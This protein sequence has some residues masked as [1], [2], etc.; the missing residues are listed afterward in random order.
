M[1]ILTWGL[2]FVALVVWAALGVRLVRRPPSLPEGWELLPRRLLWGVVW[3]AAL[4]AGSSGP[5]LWRGH[6][7]DVPPNASAGSPSGTTVLE[8]RT[9]FAI[10]RMARTLDHEGE[11]LRTER[12]LVLRLPLGLLAFF[13]GVAILLRGSARHRPLR[14]GGGLALVVLLTAGGCAGDGDA[15][16]SDDRAPSTERVFADGSWDTLAYIEVA[17]S[18]TL[19]F[20]V[21]NVTAGPQGFWVMDH[22]AKKVAHFDWEGALRWYAGR[23]GQGPG[24]F[25]RLEQGVLDADGR[26]WI[27]D[28]INARVSV[29]DESGELAREVPLSTQGETTVPHGF[30]LTAEG[31]RLYTLV[32]GDGLLP[33]ALD[34]RGRAVRTGDTIA[35]SDA[36]SDRGP[37]SIALQGIVG[38]DREGDTWVYAFSMG[39]GMYRFRGTE[40]VGGRIPYVEP[41]PFPGLVREV[42]REGSTVNTVTRLTSPRFA[43][44]AVFVQDDT[45]LV[46]FRGETDH[47][48][49]LV[50]RYDLESGAYLD[51]MLLPLAGR[52]AVWEDRFVVI[53]NDP[54]PRVLALRWTG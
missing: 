49:R 31:D 23:A 5:E 15:G 50:D 35:V 38:Q 52:V 43:A 44:N 45:I 24:E 3:M 11:L 6:T 40:L 20:S 18:D 54:T 36:V 41:V 1:M 39:D 7:T 32:L 4:A 19:L 26:L 48:G 22:G 46:G 21:S 33:L 14:S 53:A 34:A 12:R 42:S 8:I 27:L 10:E 47:A 29:L 2:T 25:S 28:P 30:A 17:L 16:A 51:S 37:T 9:P 13:I